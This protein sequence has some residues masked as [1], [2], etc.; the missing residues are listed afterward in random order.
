MQA[1]VFD[2]YS[3]SPG[4]IDVDLLQHKKLTK[5]SFPSSLHLCDVIHCLSFGAV[6][7]LIEDLLIH[8]FKEKIRA[9]LKNSPA[10]WCFA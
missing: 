4:F 5:F 1:D 10:G 8:V 7:F 6:S 9:I 2:I 3:E